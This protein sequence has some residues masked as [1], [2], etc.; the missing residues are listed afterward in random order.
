MIRQMISA[1]RS[2]FAC[3]NHKLLWTDGTVTPFLQTK[4]KHNVLQ[5][6]KVPFQSFPF[7]LL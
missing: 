3:R 6:W 4:V 7:Y 2:E 1:S 5:K